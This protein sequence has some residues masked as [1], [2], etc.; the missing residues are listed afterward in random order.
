MW[1]SRTVRR[2]VNSSGG[3]KSTTLCKIQKMELASSTQFTAASFVMF[4]SQWLGS[5]P[6]GKERQSET[7]DVCAV[8][9]VEPLGQHVGD[10]SPSEHF[11]CTFILWSLLQRTSGNIQKVTSS[12]HV[13]LIG[14]VLADH[15]GAIQ[16][17]EGR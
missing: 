9:E 17:F 2:L 10:E 13:W 16:G 14:S 8:G 1:S 3:L 6:D 4:V 11:L 15:C 5:L 7:G 12:G